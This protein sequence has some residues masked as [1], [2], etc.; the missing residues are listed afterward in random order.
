MFMIAV[1]LVCN[2]IK[3]E[4]I[5]LSSIPIDRMVGFLVGVEVVCVVRIIHY[6][7]AMKNKETLQELQIA[8]SDERNQMIQRKS[9]QVTLLLSILLLAYGAVIASFFEVFVFYTLAG[10]MIVLLLLYLIVTLYYQK[11]I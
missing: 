11:H 8:E 3:G 9:G 7:K 5:Q 2:F 4:A 10:V 6:K 1:L